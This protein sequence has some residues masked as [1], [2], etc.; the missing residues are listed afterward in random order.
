[1]LDDAA[2]GLHAVPQL[3]R[4][5]PSTSFKPPGRDRLR[6]DLLM[7]TEGTTV[8]ILA[9]PELQAHATALPW[10]RYLTEESLPSV[11]IGR[12]SIVAVNVP[13]PERL[14]WHK[15]LVSQLRHETSE[16]APKDLEQAA[17]VV[18]VLT[19]AAPESL[20]DALSAV[21][22]RALKKT[23]QGAS[24]VLAR[25]RATKHVEAAELL[26]DLTSR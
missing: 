14:A 10:L 16:K 15:M 17:I 20:G 13:R 11:V 1:M 12:S 8:R 7:P 24:R 3:D 23:R 9:A 2:L 26:A 4:R 21:P 6:V 19:E 18:A 5:A 25:L 22:K